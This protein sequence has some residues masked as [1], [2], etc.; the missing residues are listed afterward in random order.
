MWIRF[1]APMSR[2]VLPDS[3][4]TA[5]F[6]FPGEVLDLPETW[7]REH[8][9]AGEAE[10][11]PNPETI[12]PDDPWLPPSLGDAPLTVACVYRTGGIYDGHDYVGRLARA[13][14]RHLSRP[15]R[16]VCLTDSQD[17][18]GEGVEVV[19]LLHRWPGFWAKVE[20]FRPGLFD[21]PVLY[22]DLDTVICGDL[23]DLANAADP[24]LMAWDLARGWINSSLMRWSVDLS[25]IHEAMLA[26]P[27]AVMRRLTDGKGMWG[28]QGLVQEALLARSIV[29]RWAQD[30]LPGQIGWHPYGT[31]DMPAP[32]GVRVSMF[33]GNPKPHEISSDW[34]SEHWR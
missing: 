34:L 19:P 17:D 2:R 26:E 1:T 12:R 15:H 11:A 3:A 14:A 21:G 5:F 27:E 22:L 4:R 9:D 33:Y 28:D 13:V 32:D 29:W 10:L 23:A 25:C 8:L 24:V 7:A 18:L 31:R 20:L 16:F 6:Y 30:L